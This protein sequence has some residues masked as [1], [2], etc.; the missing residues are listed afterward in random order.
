M[1]GIP[2]IRPRSL[3]TFLPN[4]LTEISSF[5]HKELQ[6]RPVGLEPLVQTFEVGAV[7]SVKRCRLPNRCKFSM[8]ANRL[9]GKARVHI[10]G[11]FF[12][13]IMSLYPSHGSRKVVGHALLPLSNASTALLLFNLLL[14]THG[15]GGAVTNRIPRFPRELHMVAKGMSATVD[16]VVQRRRRVGLEVLPLTFKTQKSSNHQ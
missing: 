12:A 6:L 11:A 14:D 8:E 9:R 3:A 10:S 16:G 15:Q 13:F 1:L 2:R 4:C 5:N 7:P